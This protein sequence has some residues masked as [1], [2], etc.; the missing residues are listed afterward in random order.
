MNLRRKINTVLITFCS[1]GVFHTGNAKAEMN[2]CTT[3]DLAMLLY[4][5]SY[6]YRIPVPVFYGIIDQ[7]SKWNSKAVSSSGAIG[8]MQVMPVHVKKFGL[9][10]EALF[11]PCINVQVGTHFFAELY[12]KYNGNID[13]ALAAYNAGPAVVERHGG[14]PPIKETKKY[15]QEVKKKT[16]AYAVTY[17]TNIGIAWK[18]RA[19]PLIAKYP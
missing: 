6:E 11:N 15:V 19:S 7:E 2:Q 1:F 18:Y 16:I 14:V 3:K 9:P 12:W 17:G 10:K 4:K 8:L 13:L 5:A